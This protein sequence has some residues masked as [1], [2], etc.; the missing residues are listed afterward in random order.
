[1]YKRVLVL[2]MA[3]LLLAGGVSASAA[4]GTANDPLITV[5]YAKSW[6]QSL[7]EDTIPQIDKKLGDFYRQVS[8]SL[9]GVSAGATGKRIT[10]AQ[11]GTLSIATGA[12]VTVVSGAATVSVISGEMVNVSVGSAASNGKLNRNHRYIACENTSAV[13]TATSPSIFIVDGKYTSTAGNVQFTDVPAGKWYYGYVYSAVDM[14]LI[15]GLTDTSYGPDKQLTVA[16]AIKLAACMHQLYN[17]GEVTLKNGK[18]WY[19]S[20]LDYAIQNG[21]AEASYGELTSEQYNKAISRR[22]YVH[23]FYNA[24]PLS[25]FSGKNSVADDAIPDVKLGDRFAQEIYT[26]YRAGILDGSKDDGSFVPDSAIKRSEVAAIMA[27]MFD[28]TERKTITLP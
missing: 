10:L 21:I 19:T 22:E 17:D 16:Q 8:N 4:A 13:V 5:S 14:G 2:L 12:S 28:E 20:Y 24:L 18:P 6:G 1:M 25:E 23:L 7:L 9:G 3:V 15:D 11:G 26:F 27:R